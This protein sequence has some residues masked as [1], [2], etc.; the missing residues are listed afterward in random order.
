MNWNDYFFNMI[1]AVKLKSKD[2]NSQFGCII[3]GPDNEI[4]STGYNSFPRGINDNIPKRKKR[5]EKYLW[6]EHAERNAIYNAARVGTPT[7]GCTIYIQSMPC[8]EC[9]RAII[10]SG[11]IK[12]I[13]DNNEFIKYQS[14]KY[15][16]KIFERVNQM[17]S[18]A[19]ISVI[20]I[21]RNIQKI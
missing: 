4:R 16:K 15:D 11:I 21:D 8:M 5:P 13:Y 3:I 6:M 20:G 1:E 17:L 10:Q 12:I 9:A 14:I 2:P 18:E 7:K 19:G